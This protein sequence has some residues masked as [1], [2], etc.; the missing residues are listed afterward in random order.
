MDAYGIGGLE[1]LH[2]RSTEEIEWFWNAV[3]KELKIE[4]YEPYERVLDS[5]RGIAWT[6]WCCGGKMNVVHNCLDKWRGTPVGGKEAVR[7]EGENGETRVLTY[8]EL[9]RSVCRIANALRALGIKKGVSVALFMPMMPESV[10]ALLAVAKVGGIILPLF[11]GYGAAAVTE[12]LRDSGARFLLTVDGFYRRGQ[13]VLV[14]PVVDAALVSATSVEHVLVLRQLGTPISWCP[15]RD[16]W[17]HEAVDCQSDDGETE[18]TDAEDPL[19]I[20]YTSGTTGSPKGALHTHC[21]FP[22]K[23]AQ[24][25]VHGL[26]VCQEDV[27]YWVT[28]MGWMM[29]PWEIFGTMLLGATMVLYEGALDFPGP[30]RLWSLIE[31]HRVSIL[32]VSPT[33]I[34][35]LMPY[36]TVPA[37]QHELSSLRILG[38]TGEPWNPDPWLWFFHTAGKGRLPIVNYSGGTEVSGG[39]VVGNVLSPLKPC[40]FAGPVPGIAAD[41]VNEE[42]TSLRGEVGELVVRKPW[43]GMTRGFWNDPERYFQT[44][45]SRFPDVWVHGDWAV[46]DEDGL[47]YILG[48]SDDTIKIAGKRLGPAEVESVLVGHPAVSEAAAIGVPDPIKGEALVCFCVLK[49]GIQV[50]ERLR[51]ELRTRVSEQLGKPLKPEVLRFLNDLP[52]TRNA[53][54]MRRI[55]RA[56]YLKQEPGDLSALENPYSVEAVR[57][58]L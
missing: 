10:A 9:N 14:K 26:D 54:I 19:M 28:D 56:A 41:V 22:I 45:W 8:E 32:G 43:I 55:I 38:S 17:W 25:M 39:L 11:S 47:W 34:R 15:G 30:D 18:R 3:L 20:I 5:S 31:R 24:D 7:W 36:G 46:V 6:R 2:R 16:R 50:S 51:E 53:K 44:Y 40:A 4:F 29:G 42:G 52:K 23:A 35:S 57:K 12:R 58:A 33:L 37:D 48:R 49:P 13:S 21:G 1:E 27:L